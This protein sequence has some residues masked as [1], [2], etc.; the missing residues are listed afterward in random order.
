VV[1]GPTAG[2]EAL[3]FDGT[4]DHLILGPDYLY[5]TNSGL[6]V[7]ALVRSDVAA[8]TLAQDHVLDFGGVDSFGTHGNSYGLSY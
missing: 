7:V 8:G 4:N 1:A 6:T 2:V 5:S 3:L